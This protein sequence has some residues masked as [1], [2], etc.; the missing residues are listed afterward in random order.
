MCNLPRPAGPD[1][2]PPGRLPQPVYV[3]FALRP[4]IQA[5]VCYRRDREP[6]AQPR[7]V[8]A[9]ALLTRLQFV[10]DVGGIVSVQDGG[11]VLSIPL[12]R[13]DRPHDSVAAPVR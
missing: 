4:D 6:Q 2:G 3:Q 10:R 13:L 1:R 11:T 5:S 7:P 9:A 12:L 8:P